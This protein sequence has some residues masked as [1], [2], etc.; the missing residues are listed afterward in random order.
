[1]TWKHWIFVK[2]IRPS[3]RAV[4]AGLWYF[5]SHLPEEPVE[6]TVELSVIKDDG[7]TRDYK[8]DIMSS[9][10]FQLIKWLYKENYCNAPN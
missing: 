1:M 4:T 3:Q 5:L 8:L 6:K 10:C 2:G 7:A 9:L